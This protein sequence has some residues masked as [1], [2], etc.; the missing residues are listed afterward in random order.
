VFRGPAIAS[1]ASGNLVS[2]LVDGM[3]ALRFATTA[4]FELSAASGWEGEQ[5][6]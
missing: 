6:V 4:I 1:A 3:I 2:G 5:W